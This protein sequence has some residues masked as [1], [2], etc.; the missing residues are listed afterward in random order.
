MSEVTLAIITI[1]LSSVSLGSC[2]FVIYLYAA[3]RELR[4]DQFTIVLQII[5]FDFIYDLILLS[6]SIGYLFLSD[7]DFL[8]SYKPVL[9]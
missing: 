9:C 8:L 2:S 7:S 3:F 1:V 5:L 6:D 4:N